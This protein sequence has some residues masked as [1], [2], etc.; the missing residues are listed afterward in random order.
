MS[1][2]GNL[3]PFN[4]KSEVKISGVWLRRIDLTVEVLIEVDGEWL[5]ITQAPFDNYFSNI[6]N[7]D[8][9]GIRNKSSIGIDRV[10]N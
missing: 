6:C 2:F 5:K 3:E 7:I 9:S 1:K 8:S 10:E 4:K